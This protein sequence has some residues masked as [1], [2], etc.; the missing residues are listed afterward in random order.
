MSV[1]S[2]TYFESQEASAILDAAEE[3]INVAES[4][5]GQARYVASLLLALYD[6]ESYLF[7]V[8]NLRAIDSGLTNK[9]LVLMRFS[10]LARINVARVI[11]DGDK[12]L[13]GLSKK[14]PNLIR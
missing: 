3:L 1:Q 9:C 12:R 5:S 13:S 2:N 6:S 7:D 14:Y 4:F 11:V 10:S 8:S